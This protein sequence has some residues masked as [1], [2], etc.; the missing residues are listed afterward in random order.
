MEPQER[1]LV[2]VFGECPV[3]EPSNEEAVDAPRLA[4]EQLTERCL[5]PSLERRH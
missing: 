2:E 5:V 1:L 4:V 3:P